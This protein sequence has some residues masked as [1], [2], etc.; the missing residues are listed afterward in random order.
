MSI[1]T[2]MQFIV[3]GVTIGSVYA[4]VGLGFNLIFNATDI[5]NF[6]QGEFV[7]LGGVLAA[8]AITQW[9][10]P[11]AVALIAVALAVGGLGALIDFATISRVRHASVMTLVMITLGISVFLR[12]ARSSQ[13]GPIPFIFRLSRKA[14]RCASS[15]PS[16]SCRRSM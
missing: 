11:T 1:A 14:C 9:H 5:I 3:S 2:I 12:Q 15:E 8:I 16:S 7:M 10:W 6:A 13:L 4:L